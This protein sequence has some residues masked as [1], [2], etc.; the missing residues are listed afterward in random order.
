ML[1]KDINISNTGVATSSP[2][3]NFREIKNQPATISISNK[4]GKREVN[5]SGMN[6]LFFGISIGANF[7]LLSVVVILSS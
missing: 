5:I 3:P 2:C 6:Q 1:P 7:A 4:E